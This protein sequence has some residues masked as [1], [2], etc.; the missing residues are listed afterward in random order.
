MMKK[1]YL[2]RIVGVG[3]TIGGDN[4]GLYRVSS[5]SF[6]HRRIV[7]V[8]DGLAVVP[9]QGFAQ[10]V[11]QNPYIAYNCARIVRGPR[12]VRWAVLANGAHTDPIAEKL[13]LGLPPKDALAFALLALDYEKD[14]YN[15][16]RIG[17]L[18]PARGEAGWLAVVRHDALVVKE[19]PL[20]N[21]QVSYVSTNGAQ[22]VSPRQVAPVRA[23]EAEKLA[24]EA[25]HGPGFTHFTH[26]VTAAALVSAGRTFRS[27][28]YVCQD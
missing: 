6:P 2:G 10:D 7:R 15:T 4:V 25:C 27:G 22:D 21:G 23:S 11:S 13:A 19:V 3:K 28:W 24:E 16:P 12:G 5:R 18:L 9:R 26:P 17:A 8:K 14:G 1:V 20:A